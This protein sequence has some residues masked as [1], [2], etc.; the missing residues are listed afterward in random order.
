VEYNAARERLLRQT[1]HISFSE[2]LI[3]W[4]ESISKK[5]GGGLF[6]LKGGGVAAAEK[7][8][9]ALCIKE[10][11]MPGGGQSRAAGALAYALSAARAEYR[12]PAGFTQSGG[13][14]ERD[15]TAVLPGVKSGVSIPKPSYFGF[16]FD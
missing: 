10:L 7:Y 11:L 9:G 4:Q 1:P 12:T 13:G 6:A 3:R 16:L 2:R 14:D 8:G 5:T 15:T